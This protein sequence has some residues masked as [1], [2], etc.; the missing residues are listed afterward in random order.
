MLLHALEQSVV[1]RPRIRDAAR[2]KTRLVCLLLALGGAYSTQS[3]ADP[4]RD[5]IWVLMFQRNG[6]GNGDNS[7]V[8]IAFQEAAR[9]GL[10]APR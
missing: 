4:A 9:K 2:P 7:D 1:G 3:W 5:L 6:Q 10:P 8:R